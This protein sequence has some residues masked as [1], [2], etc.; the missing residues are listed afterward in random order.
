LPRRLPQLSHDFHG[1]PLKCVGHSDEA[2][3]HRK[4]CRMWWIS[5]DINSGLLGVDAMSDRRAPAHISRPL[6]VQPAPMDV[7]ARAGHFENGGRKSPE[8]LAESTK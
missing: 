5:S 1:H 2:A 8:L 7:C 4:I 3:A 6:P